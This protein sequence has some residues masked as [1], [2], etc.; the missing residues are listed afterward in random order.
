MVAG[1]SGPDSVVCLAIGPQRR[2]DL[3]LVRH[4]GFA[5][6]RRFVVF[7][8]LGLLDFAAGYDSGHG[9]KPDPGMVHGF[10]ARTG[11]V[12]AEVAVIGDNLHDLEMGRRGGVGLVVGVLTGT[13]ERAELTAHADHVLDGIRDLEA[14]LDSLA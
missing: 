12:P 7:K 3:A 1:E 6:S 4:P 14:L 2:A 8:L 11:L 13:G 9:F 10:C 5:T